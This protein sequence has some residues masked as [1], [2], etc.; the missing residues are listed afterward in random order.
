MAWDGQFGRIASENRFADQDGDGAPDLAIGR[1][2]ASTAQEA[3]AL[4]DKIQ[5]GGPAIVRGSTQ[6]VAV[7]DH[8]PSDLPFRDEAAHIV[9]PL[10]MDPVWVDVADGIDTARAA[11][12]AAWARGPVAVQY[13]GHSGVDTWADEHLLTPSDVASLAH[14]GLPPVVFT[15]TCQAQWYQYH[16]G[17]SVNEA[18]LHTPEGGALATFG[19]TGISEPGRQ[20]L[21]AERVF[22]G[23]MAGRPLGEAVRQAK[24]DVLAQHSGMQGVVEGFTLLGDPALVVGG[25]PSAAGGAEQER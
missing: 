4:V 3:E 14:L 11:L 19:P 1:L 13:F 8:G 23:V 22:A 7:D 12:F 25:L 9:A 5:A 24:A 10:P 21:L 17:P 18:L 15:W 2:P 16:L 20:A 6:V